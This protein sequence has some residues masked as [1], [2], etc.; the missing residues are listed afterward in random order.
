MTNPRVESLRRRVAADPSSRAFLE[1]AR[2]YHDDGQLEEAAKVCA[3]GVRRNPG[4]LSARALLGRV[5]YDM[6][7]IEES[8]AAMEYVLERAPDNLMARRLLAEIH[9]QQG[10]LEAALERYRALLAFKP[11]DQDAGA[12]IEDIERR[13][14]GR[15]VD[16]DLDGEES[17][18]GVLATPTL[19]EI[20]LQQGH[21]VKAARLYREILRG[22]PANEEARARLAQI[23]RDYPVLDPAVKL[24]RKKIRI[25]GDWLRAMR[26]G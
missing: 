9:L 15:P 16:V 24:R 1:L 6:N 7:L 21:A 17:P 20:Y 22:D 23:E 18:H 13:L 12:K 2:I 25:L 26:S 5:Y 14:E 11:D 8:R 4:D 19:A 10:N 3:E